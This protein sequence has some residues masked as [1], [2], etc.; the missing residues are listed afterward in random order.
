MKKV[1]LKETF[2]FLLVGKRFAECVEEHGP[3]YR[4]AYFQSPQLI[5]RIAEEDEITP[6]GASV[7]CLAFLIDPKNQNRWCM[8]EKAVQV[9]LGRKLEGSSDL[10]ELSL[11][12]RE[13]IDLL[14]ALLEQGAEPPYR[15]FSRFA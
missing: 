12:L 6:D 1:S 10:Q 9:M 3:R 4:Q 7:T 5:L 8:F 14:L 15:D 11:H 2:G 13:Y